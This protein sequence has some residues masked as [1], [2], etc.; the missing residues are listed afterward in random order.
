VEIHC[1]DRGDKMLEPLH[2]ILESEGDSWLLHALV[3]GASFVAAELVIL[4][5][6]VIKEL[7]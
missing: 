7:K 4:L 3:I 1:N 2:S 6:P 5:P